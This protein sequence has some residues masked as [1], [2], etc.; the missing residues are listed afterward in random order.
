MFAHQRKCN[1]VTQGINYSN[2]LTVGSL[3][4]T[5]MRAYKSP[6]KYL[7]TDAKFRHKD[8]FRHKDHKTRQGTNKFCMTTIDKSKAKALRDL[9]ERLTDLKW[10]SF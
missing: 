6:M 7:V 5:I 10:P 2:K 4:G 1:S 3:T 9:G 8:Q